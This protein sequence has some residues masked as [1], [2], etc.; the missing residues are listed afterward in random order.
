MKR[1]ITVS[2]DDIDGSEGDDV[3]EVTLAVD[4][5]TYELDLSSANRAKLDEALAP[6]LKAGRRVVRKRRGRAATT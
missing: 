1:Q 5:V 4:G 3:R 2:V 6:W